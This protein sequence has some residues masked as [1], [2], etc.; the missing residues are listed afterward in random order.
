LARQ[1]T[2]EVLDKMKISIEAN[3]EGVT[4]VARTALR[5]KLHAAL[6]D[7]LTDVSFNGFPKKTKMQIYF[8]S[9]LLVILLQV[10]VDAILSIYSKDHPLDLHMVEI[11]EMQHK[12]EMDSTLIPGIVMDHGGRHPD[13]PKRVED[14][15]ILTCNVSM[16]YEKRLG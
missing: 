16:E 5:T 14:A 10:C 4:G 7:Q 11:M 13:M 12:T 3:K 15:F 8:D 6:A 2:I 1:R 9:N